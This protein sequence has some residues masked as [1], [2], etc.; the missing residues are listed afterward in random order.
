MTFR[1]GWSLF[2]KG[3]V[4][5][6]GIPHLWGKNRKEGGGHRRVNL[7]WVGEKVVGSAQLTPPT[8]VRIKLSVKCVGGQVIVL[9]GPGYTVS[10]ILIL[11]GSG[12]CRACRS[13]LGWSFQSHRGCEP[14]LR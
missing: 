5:G 10:A 1:R 4:L 13:F 6:S 12:E 3:Q 14:F 8:S 7:P 2:A 9:Q 11:G